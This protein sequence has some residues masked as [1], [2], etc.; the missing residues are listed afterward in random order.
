MNDKV[1]FTFFLNFYFNMIYI[2]IFQ[3]K[4]TE[5]NFNISFVRLFFILKSI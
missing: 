4:K 1:L 2:D 5:I 3:Q